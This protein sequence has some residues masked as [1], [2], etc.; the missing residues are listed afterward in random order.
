MNF[1]IIDESCSFN[2]STE[3]GYSESHFLKL[4]NIIELVIN[5]FF[6]KISLDMP[7]Y[8]YFAS[9]NSHKNKI[10]STN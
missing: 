3:K 1:R 2:I 6:K 7:M 8:D 10:M 9:I 5:T 4:R